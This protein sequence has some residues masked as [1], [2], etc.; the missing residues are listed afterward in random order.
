MFGTWEVISY[1]GGEFLRVVFNG[2]AMIMGDNEFT[3][4]MRLFMLVGFLWVLGGAAFNMRLLGS[5]NWLMG[6]LLV[7][8]LMLVPKVNVMIK[9]RLDPSVSSV[10]SN[11]PLGV[12]L[13][14]SFTSQLGDYLTRAYETVFVMPDD[15]NYSKNGMLFGQRL[16]EASTRMNIMDARVM[17]N[18]QEFFNTCVLFDVGL[19]LYT[20]NQLQNSDDLWVFLKGNTSQL[21]RYYHRHGDGTSDLLVCRTAAESALEHDMILALTSSQQRLAIQQLGKRVLSNWSTGGDHNSISP[22]LLDEAVNKMLILSEGAYGYLAKLSMDASHIMR[23]NIMINAMRDAAQGAAIAND[24]SA[25]AIS[26]AVARA[27]AERRTTWRVMGEMALR[28]LP[29]L[30]NIFE[31]LIYAVFPIFLL[32]ALVAPKQATMSYAQSLVWIQLWAPLYAILH[33]AMSLYT[34]Y[35]GHT[36]LLTSEG[37]PGLTILTSSGLGEAMA[38]MGYVAGYLSMSIPMI[39]YMLVNKGGMMMASLAGGVMTGI[40]SIAQR[41][42]E[43]ATTGNISFGNN[44][45]DNINWFKNDTSVLN[46]SGYGSRTDSLGNTYQDT[47]VG[48]TM[49]NNPIS[50]A[51]GGAVKSAVSTQAAE[52]VNAVASQAI[53]YSNQLGQTAGTLSKTG[54]MIQQATA[55]GH[56]FDQGTQSAYEQGYGRM[57]QLAGDFARKFGYDQRSAMESMLSVGA[58]A[59]GGFEVFGNGVKTE[60]GGKLAGT[61]NAA[62]S[63]GFQE[64]VKWLE[65]SGFND[66]L[67]QTLTA[68]ER[69]TANYSQSSG[70]SK[71]TE[72]NA[73]LAET[74]QSGETL[75]ATVSEAQSWQQ[76]KAHIDERGANFSVNA[77]ESVRQFMINHPLG[78]G[79]AGKVDE[80]LAKARN[81]DAESLSTVTAW[82]NTWAKE[83]GANEIA[84]VAGAPTADGV[85][86]FGVQAQAEVRAAAPD[87]KAEQADQARVLALQSGLP[88]GQSIQGQAA[89]IASQVE[90]R[91]NQTTAT[92]EKA[93]TGLSAKGEVLVG[94]VKTE[95]I[96]GQNAA[97]RAGDAVSNSAPAQIIEQGGAAARAMVTGNPDSR[98]PIGGA[99][100]FNDMHPDREQEAQWRM[101]NEANNAGAGNVDPKA[102][103][104]K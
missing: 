71:A 57:Q 58:S 69:L 35:A 36:A 81:G 95:V 46:N 44:S 87:L 25:A 78:P 65:Q 31:A 76:V 102:P 77:Q 91:Q 104:K 22:A 4:L 38:D 83:Q 27:E 67:K 70:D 89:G 14:A 13:T 42:A 101:Q 43:E 18:F 19:G 32:M 16:V 28:T 103:F 85:R 82:T 12:G 62:S 86:A 40:Q 50:A 100:S 99:P 3:T 72:L 8:Y 39:A 90:G 15:L 34:G 93:S 21:R 98:S 48:S 66:A 11:V 96:G 97:K 94:D 10:V 37:A 53:N 49:N 47:A 54:E 9:D 84:R 51:A 1:G 30:R 24:S 2:V 17:G 20:W 6:A 88:T 52:S 79:G 41:G 64:Q 56:Q 73:S 29:L 26:Y 33:S 74:R 7:V 75:N 68:G 55:T 60:L 61:S 80:L 59:S 5:F 92:L 45:Q 23:Q 63:E